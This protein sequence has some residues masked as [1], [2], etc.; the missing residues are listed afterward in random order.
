MTKEKAQVLMF[1]MISKENVTMS[2]EL[3]APTDIDKGINNN[4]WKSV[5]FT[6][7]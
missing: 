3:W 2:I 4:L 6:E 1:S 7:A 5:G